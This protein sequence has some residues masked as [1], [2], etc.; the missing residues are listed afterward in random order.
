MSTW[1]SV[2][3]YAAYS[4]YPTTS[5][6]SHYLPARRFQSL[7]ISGYGACFA[8]G[9]Y[10]LCNIGYVAAS[11]AID[12]TGLENDL[13]SALVLM[14]AALAQLGAFIVAAVFFLLFMH[15][16]ASNVRAF[17]HEHLEHS[18]GWC[19]GWWFIPF[20]NLVKPMQAM[21]EIWR[22]SEPP[23]ASTWSWWNVRANTNR[24]GAWWALWLGSRVLNV[25]AMRAHQP[26]LAFVSTFVMISA[27]SV[28][29]Q[30]VVTLML[31]QRDTARAMHLA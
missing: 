20:A 6:V 4:A 11:N 31:R 15:T 9:A 2:P 27:A 30:L 25:L 12:P 13:A 17:G 8:I 3:S 23:G 16:A 29:V 10:V 1:G 21:S 28:A 26:L 19:V 18:P 22:K 5:A 24:V 14:L 7:S